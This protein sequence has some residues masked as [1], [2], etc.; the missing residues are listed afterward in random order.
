MQIF[1]NIE[2]L[3]WCRGWSKALR[4]TFS[5]QASLDSKVKDCI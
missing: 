2:R 5:A 3:F 1:A 4:A